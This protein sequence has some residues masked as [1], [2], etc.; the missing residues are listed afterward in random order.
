MMSGLEGI[1]ALSLAANILEIISFGSK[2][3]KLCKTVYSGESFSKDLKQ[4]A[5][6]LKDIASQIQAVNTP[7]S[8]SRNDKP[9]IEVSMKCQ[10]TANDLVDELKFL[11]GHIRKGSLVATLKVAAKTTWRKRRLDKLGKDLQHIQGQ[12]D[13]VLITRLW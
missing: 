4:N 2:A 3:V 9:L 11:D 6:F 10:K 13:S 12:M 7:I 5:E 8:T 1:A